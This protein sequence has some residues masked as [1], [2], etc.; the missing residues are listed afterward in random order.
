MLKSN[1]KFASL[2][3]AG[4]VTATLAF[5]AQAQEV[6]LALGMPG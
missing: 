2:L 5:Q 3:L 6:K 1:V 4:A